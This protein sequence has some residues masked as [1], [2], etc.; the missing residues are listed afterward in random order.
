VLPRYQAALAELL[1]RAAQDRDRPSNRCRRLACREE[2]RLVKPKI[3]AGHV[4]RINAS[5]LHLRDNRCQVRCVRSSAVRRGQS[6]TDPRQEGCDGTMLPVF[7]H[8]QKARQ[9]RC[10]FFIRRQVADDYDSAHLLDGRRNQGGVDEDRL[11]RK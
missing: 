11:A 9:K 2:S 7:G 4:Q 5:L 3:I 8:G 1:I 6:V 10:N